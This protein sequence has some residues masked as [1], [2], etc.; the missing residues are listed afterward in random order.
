MSESV[1]VTPPVS[2]AGAIVGRRATRRFDPSR[3]LADDLLRRLLGLA[4]RAPS[5]YNLQPWRFLVVRS[6][7]NRRRLRDCA[8][9]QPKVTEAPVVVVVLGYRGAFATHLEPMLA[10][11]VATGGMTPE[12]AGEV[13]GRAEATAAR[14]ADPSTWALRST[15]LAAATL[16][17]AAEG[18]GVA[19]APMEG[20]DPARI[21]EAFGVPD[22]HVICCLVALGYALEHA[23]FP[24]RFGLEEVCYEEHFGQPWT[25]GEPGDLE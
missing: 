18:L 25:L 2:A 20:F 17:I 8:F 1:E 21:K 14:L 22:D 7:R 6:E 12:E 11:R 19:S 9:N 16:M 10:A 3:P 23:P 13:R 15:M 4:T 24:G 5:G